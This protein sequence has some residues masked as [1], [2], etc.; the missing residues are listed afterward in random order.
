MNN[1]TTTMIKNLNNMMI[2][3]NDNGNVSYLTNNSLPNNKN[4]NKNENNKEANNNNGNTNNN[5]TT[6]NNNISELITIGVNKTELGKENTS[7]TPLNLNPNSP[8]SQRNVKGKSFLKNDLN[9][10]KDKENK[11][12]DK[13][14]DKFEQT[15]NATR[16]NNGICQF[17][18]I[19]IVMFFGVYR[20][21]KGRFIYRKEKE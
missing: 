2:S 8:V 17:L 11:I 19:N 7:M 13:I 16:L 3:K 21:T 18:I 9:I 12:M 15:K 5:I 14:N 20:L 6:T 1:A 10:D 4:D